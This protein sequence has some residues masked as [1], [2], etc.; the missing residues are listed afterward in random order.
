MVKDCTTIAGRD[1]TLAYCYA[2]EVAFKKLS[3]QDVG[4]FM[5]EVS[6]SITKNRMPDI[7]KTIFLVLAAA[8]AYYNAH[9]AESPVKDTEIMNE[10]TPTELGTAL[11]KVIAL[12]QSFYDI[13]AGEDDTEDDGGYD[14]KN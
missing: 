11:G 2:T 8:M 12:R 5:D 13:P 4:D 10:A 1:V 6:A 7:D 3:G 9:D 14:T